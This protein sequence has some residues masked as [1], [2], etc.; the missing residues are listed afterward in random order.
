MKK[1][2]GGNHTMRFDWIPDPVERVFGIV[3][4]GAIIVVFVLGFFGPDEI[5][6]MTRENWMLILFLGG[7]GVGLGWRVVKW[8]RK[9]RD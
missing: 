3:I 2:Q 8:F 5:L 7:F 6:G 4:A 9:N 1:D